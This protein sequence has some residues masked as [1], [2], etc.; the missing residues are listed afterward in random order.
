VA[1]KLLVPERGRGV[2]RFCSVGLEPALPIN[3]NF[4][5]NFNFKPS[6]NLKLD[7]GHAH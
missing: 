2:Q 1:F 5:F 3:F 6:V 4:N 7:A